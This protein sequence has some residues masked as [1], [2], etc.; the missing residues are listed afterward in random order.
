MDKGAGESGRLGMRGRNS[1]CMFIGFVTVTQPKQVKSIYRTD[2][3]HHAAVLTPITL[4]R[5]PQRLRLP[6]E[7]SK[8]LTRQI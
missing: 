2:N 8:W 7:E 4:T 5:Q 3:Y 1:G 6:W